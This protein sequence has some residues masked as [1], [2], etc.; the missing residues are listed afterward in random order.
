MLRNEPVK[1]ELMQAG[2]ALMRDQLVFQ[3]A[4]GEA[5]PDPMLLG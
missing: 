1:L 4:R 2:R 3:G 5:H